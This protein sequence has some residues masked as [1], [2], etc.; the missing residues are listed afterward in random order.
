M[1]AYKRGANKKIKFN[2]DSSESPNHHAFDSKESG[3]EYPL[4]DFRTSGITNL[5]LVSKPFKSAKY[6]SNN[7][8]RRWKNLK[9]IIV[10]EEQQGSG[11]GGDGRWPVDFPTYWLVDAVPSLKPQK[12]YCDITGLPAKYVDPKTNVR[13]CSAE[14]YRV[15]KS[16]PP[17]GEQQY[18]ALRNASVVLK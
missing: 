12:K 8:N 9:Q 18:L 5:N 6:K 10:Q 2:I 13:Y 14:V 11:L 7:T 4:E 15:V 1:P 17:G 16:L 3:S